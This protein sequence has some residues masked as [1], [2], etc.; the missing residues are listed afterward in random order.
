M[1]FWTPGMCHR[2]SA[3][4]TLASMRN[5]E[6][7]RTANSSISSILA[8]MPL[9]AVTR[10]ASFPS[11]SFPNCLFPTTTYASNVHTGRTFAASPFLRA[12]LAAVAST[13]LRLNPTTLGALLEAPTRAPVAPRPLLTARYRQDCVE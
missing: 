1:N 8:S 13:G 6:P 11:V 2:D 9:M 5:G 4:N 3:S 7:V 12:F 10:D